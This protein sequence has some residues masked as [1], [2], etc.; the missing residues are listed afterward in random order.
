MNKI[1][2]TECLHCARPTLL[3]VKDRINGT[4]FLVYLLWRVEVLHV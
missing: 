2:A 1:N 4:A 3:S